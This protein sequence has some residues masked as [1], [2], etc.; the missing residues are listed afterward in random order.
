MIAIL[1]L[2]V[3]RDLF[4]H[5]GPDS[6]TEKLDIK[7]DRTM[8]G[9]KSAGNSINP[10]DNAFG[11]Y[12]LTGNTYPRAYITTLTTSLGPEEEITTFDKRDDS[13]WELLDCDSTSGES[14]QTVKAVCTNTSEASNCGIIYKGS[15]VAATIV[16][17]PE[18]CGPGKYA[19]AVSLEPS[20]NH[21]EIHRRLVKRGLEAAPV[22]DF[23]FDYDFSVIEKRADQSNVLVRIDYSDDPGYW[24]HIVCK[25]NPV[26]EVFDAHFFCSSTSRQKKERP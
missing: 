26:Q 19:V 3:Y 4:P 5:P 16:E 20:K 14:R 18:N 8:G 10:D 11:F 12:I 22:F 13:H 25:Q 15:G 1:L 6:D 21:T 17:M 7:L 23:T 2:T 24:S 9:Q